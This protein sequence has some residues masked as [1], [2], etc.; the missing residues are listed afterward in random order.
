MERGRLGIGKEREKR[1][2][3]KAWGKIEEKIVVNLE[4]EIGREREGG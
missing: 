3:G 4:G 2:E 1:K